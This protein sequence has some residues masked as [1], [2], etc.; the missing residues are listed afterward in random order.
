ML[1]DTKD[2]RHLVNEFAYQLVVESAPQELP[3]Y[4]TMRDRY[5]ADPAHYLQTP[6]DGDE[7]LAFG[8]TEVVETFTYIVF[9]IV[10]ALLAHIV[11]Q[12]SEKFKEDGGQSA[13][14]WLRSLAKRQKQPRPIFTQA[15]L[16]AISQEMD[17]LIDQETR[18]LGVHKS[19][20]YAIKNA[21]IARLTLATKPQAS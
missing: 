5:F 10:T 16:A 13:V 20:A 1:T 18:R 8:P 19:Q 9:P 14:E 4:V 17:Y 3:L 6:V 21:L 2:G 12:A 11:N 15:Q 7:A